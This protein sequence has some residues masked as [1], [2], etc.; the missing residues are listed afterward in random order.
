MAWGAQLTHLPG[1]GVTPVT[2]RTTVTFL[3]AGPLLSLNC[4]AVPMAMGHRPSC[5]L[6]VMDSMEGMGQHSQACLACANLYRYLP[7]YPSQ[8]LAWAA[9]ASPRTH[10]IP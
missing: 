2:P 10:D 4:M 5:Q 8:R 6:V 3:W 1:M 7:R 9:K